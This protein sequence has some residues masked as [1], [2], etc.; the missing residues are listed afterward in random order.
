ML[1]RRLV[2]SRLQALLRRCY[3]T[4]RQKE[5]MA[6]KL[7]P[8]KALPGVEDI[9]L[10]ASGKGGVGKSTTAVNLALSAAKQ[11]KRVGLLDAD[12]YGPSIPLM[13]N[14]EGQEA[15]DLDED[16]TKMLPM[17]NYGI[18]CMS[19]GF[20]IKNPED[21][22]VW[23]GPMVMGA[24]QKLAFGTN[25]DP[26]DLLVVD[27]PPGTGDIHLSVAQTMPV[28][29][30]VVVSTPQSVALID[31]R[32]AV[33]MFRAVKIPII[34]LVENMSSFGCP[35]CGKESRIFGQNGAQKLALEVGVDFLGGIPLE[36]D[37][38]QTSEE[39]T[40]MATAN[41]NSESA[42]KYADI[43]NRVLSFLAAAR[44]T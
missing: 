14:L 3:V 26:I 8:K 13:M 34:G 27:M 5:L 24:V 17:V 29:G 31:A 4:D 21:A 36:P 16:G 41:P 40:P 42:M 18:K 28:S 7:P 12:V 39:G 43:S 6:K 20:L 19:M 35:N 38:M 25:W 32:K 30:A 1:K 44:N 2:Y 9:V 23:R 33:S 37:I 22:L 11:G 15:P 10:V